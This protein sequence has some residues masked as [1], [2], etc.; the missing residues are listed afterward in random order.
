LNSE[1]V[2]DYVDRMV[3]AAPPLTDQQRNRLAELLRP[4]RRTGAQARN[5]VAAA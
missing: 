5:E 2:D 1:T 4:V 3:A